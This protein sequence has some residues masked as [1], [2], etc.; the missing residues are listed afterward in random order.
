MMVK[1]FTMNVIFRII[2]YYICF[3]IRSESGKGKADDII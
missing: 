1:I 3:V 2:F